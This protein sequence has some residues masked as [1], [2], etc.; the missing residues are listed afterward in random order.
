MAVAGT[1]LS[2]VGTA[3]MAAGMIS[4]V[5]HAHEMDRQRAMARY[6]KEVAAQCEDCQSLLAYAATEFEDYRDE[7]GGR[8]PSHEDGSMLA[9]KNIDPWENEIMYN[10]DADLATLRSAGPDGDF[11]TR[12]DLTYEIDGKTDHK[13]LLPVDEVATSDT[14]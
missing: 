3:V 1:A 6:H 4:V 12:D 13:P 9:I 8:L 11:F 2:L 7:N 5:N 10:L 14:E